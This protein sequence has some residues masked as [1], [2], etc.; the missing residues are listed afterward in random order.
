MKEIKIKCEEM[1]PHWEQNEFNY[2]SVHLCITLTIS[3]VD[4][5]G[6]RDVYCLAQN[7]FIFMQ[8]FGT[9]WSNSMFVPPQGVE[10]MFSVCLF[11]RG[12]EVP[13]A[14][15]PRSCL[16]MGEGTLS[17]LW[18]QIVS[19]GYP[20]SCPKFCPRSCLGRRRRGYPQSRPPPQAGQ[21]VPPNTTRIRGTPWQENKCCTT[22]AVSL[23]RSTRWTFLCCFVKTHSAVFWL[24]WINRTRKNEFAFLFLLKC[25]THDDDVTLQS[26]NIFRNPVQIFWHSGE[27]SWRFTARTSTPGQSSGYDPVSIPRAITTERGSRIHLWK[28]TSQI[29]TK[30]EHKVGYPIINTNIIWNA[31]LFIDTPTMSGTTMVIRQL[32]LHIIQH[33][34][35]QQGLFLNNQDKFS[36]SS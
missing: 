12:R 36:H 13:L 11:T 35:G 3:V 20:Q 33:C 9:S 14:F 27:H 15:G 34:M 24:I 18:S 1:G 28:Q 23:L 30:I 29:I 22:R 4:L 10:V 17:V 25:S 2:N 6:M 19:R 5:G 26:R 31:I 32:R 8:F 7:F 16:G 21:G